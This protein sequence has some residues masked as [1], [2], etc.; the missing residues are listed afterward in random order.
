MKRLIFG[1]SLMIMFSI[2]VVTYSQFFYKQMQEN[3]IRLHILAKSNSP[4]D[5]EIKLA[6]RDE[7]LSATK[8]IDIKDTKKFLTIA[9]ESANQYLKDNNI[10]YCA[11]GEMGYFHFPKKEYENITLPA[12]KYKGVRI[13]LD[14]G[15]GENWWCVM[16]PPVCT[17]TNDEALNTLKNS[18][19]DNNYD[20]ITQKPR[21][22]FWLLDF[23]NK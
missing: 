18:L 4:E 6:V 15:K 11:K 19:S 9:Q 3:I 5:Q 21:V 20:I 8:D 13:V 14:D 2:S 7:V 12:G 1:L 23:L 17:A 22:R 16:Y 10:P